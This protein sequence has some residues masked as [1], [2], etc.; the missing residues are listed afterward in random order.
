MLH[1][2]GSKLTRRVE[3]VQNRAM[4]IILN[5]ERKMRTQELTLLNRRRFFRFELIVKILNNLDCPENC[6][7]F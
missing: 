4:R 2:C 6:Y 5:V 7:V 1:D 3:L